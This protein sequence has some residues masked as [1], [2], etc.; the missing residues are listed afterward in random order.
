MHEVGKPL[1]RSKAYSLDLLK[2][3]LG[4]LP[5]HEVGRQTL[6]EFGRKRRKESAGPVTVGT[7]ISYLRTI[8]V[9]AAAVQGVNRH[10]KLTP[11]NRPG[12]PRG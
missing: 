1:R 8:L 4:H 3:R 2:R 11:V 6:I 10:A 12:F 9:H 5:Y 7:D